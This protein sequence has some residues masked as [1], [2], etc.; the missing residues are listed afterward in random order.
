MK[1]F[2]S[3][4]Q[5]SFKFSLLINLIVALIFIGFIYSAYNIINMNSKIQ[6][7]AFENRFQSRLYFKV[8]TNLK[9]SHSFIDQ[10]LITKNLKHIENAEDI[11]LSAKADY[12]ILISENMLHGTN[13]VAESELDSI[14]SLLKQYEIFFDSNPKNDSDLYLIKGQSEQIIEHLFSHE[15][16]L[17]KNEAQ[18]FYRL[19]QFKERSKATFYYLTFMFAIFLAVLVFFTYLRWKLITKLHQQNEQLIIQARMST[20][21]VMSAE[22]AHEINSPLMVIDGRVRQLTNEFNSSDINIERAKKNFEIIQRNTKRIHNIVKNFKLLS[23]N[24]KIDQFE[25]ITIEE[26]FFELNDIII[27]RAENYQVDIKIFSQHEKVVVSIRKVQILQVLVNLVNNSIDAIKELNDKWLEVTTKIEN[28]K[29][30]FIVTDSGNGIKPEIVEKLFNPFFTTKS[31]S[32]GTGLGLSLSKK[33][34]EDHGGSLYYNDHILNT[35][36]ILSIP[37]K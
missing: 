3:T 36:F 34:A 37:L 12:N 20:L 18:K 23:K 8:I 24:G 5:L 17:W 26:I 19:S 15:S 29:I 13:L 10:Y 2:F 16:D 4:D 35:Q 1:S 7:E 28:G 33:I 6:D 9:S 31:S 14:N 32:E 22:L 21:G 30:L 25:A 27:P 11:T